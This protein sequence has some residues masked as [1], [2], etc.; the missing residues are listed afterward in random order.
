MT[1]EQAS[2]P[3]AEALKPRT[4]LYDI[5]TEIAE[6]IELQESAETDEIRD[7]AGV[8][9]EAYRE[10]LP[11]KVDDVRGYVKHCEMMAECARQESAEQAARAKLWGNRAQRTKDY[12]L[13]VMQAF[14]AKKLSGRTGDLRVQANPPSVEITREDILDVEYFSV[15]VTMNGRV[16]KLLADVLNRFQNVL[17]TL[18]PAFGNAWYIPIGTSPQPK[19]TPDKAA[20]AG[21]LKKPCPFCHGDLT[22]RRALGLEG[23]DIV[24]DQ[25][26][27]TGKATVPGAR[28]VTDKSHLRI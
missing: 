2:R 13:E 12:A 3:L 10:K 17:E 21:A 8:A 4:S 27:G 19:F 26:N 1:P 7:A 25:C 15:T 6:L 24:C 11:Q 5:A 22:M 20:I 16:W 23:A 9:L 18:S 28:L 14:K